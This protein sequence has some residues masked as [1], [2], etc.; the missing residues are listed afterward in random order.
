MKCNR[1]KELFSA[2]RDGKLSESQRCDLLGHITACPSCTEEW[3]QYNEV[4]DPVGE[5][6]AVVPEEFRAAWRRRVAEEPVPAASRTNRRGWPTM[7][8]AAAA[9]VTVAAVWVGLTGFRGPEMAKPDSVAQS[10]ISEDLGRNPGV[11]SESADESAPL[12][13][14][15]LPAPP[16]AS[17]VSP[18]EERKIMRSASVTLESGDVERTCDSISAAAVQLDGFVR[19]VSVESTEGEP[20]MGTVDISVPASRFD[21]AIRRLEAMG[22]LLRK[23]VT[24]QDVTEEYV[25]L[26]ARLR[27][28]RSQE[29]QLN[30]IMSKAR[31]VSEILAVQGELGRV[32]EEI[33]RLTGRIQFIDR[34]TE[35]SDISVTVMEPGGT[36][37]VSPVWEAL[38]R[39]GSRL[40]GSFLTLVTVILAALPWAGAGLAVFFLIRRWWARRGI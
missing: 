2:W 18:A 40:L 8:W 39:L 19:R 9:C 29:S 10:Y 24:G 22:S 31:N 1:A 23:D 32:R 7:G 26:E 37:T 11:L 6:A 15:V 20:H 35:F 33:E 12:L 3:A 4:L 16:V 21:E 28:W 25:D 30:I 5:S 34:K 27:N 14:S 38:S 13:K 17:S 36:K